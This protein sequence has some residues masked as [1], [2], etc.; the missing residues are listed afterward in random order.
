MLKR[1][2]MNKI[3]KISYVA[4]ALVCMTIQTASAQ[5]KPSAKKKTDEPTTTSPSSP[6]KKSTKTDDYFDEKGGF[7]HRLW[8]GAGGAL[9]FN[10]SGDYSLFT[11][12]LS[13]MIGYKIIGG[14]SAGPRL[15]FTYTNYKGYNTARKISSVGLI[16]YSVGA[17]V[18]YKAFQ[19][20]FAHAEYD[21][22]SIQY[23]GGSTYGIITL[24]PSGKAIKERS[25][26]SNKYL[27]LGYS[28]GGLFGYEI[29]ALYNFSITDK[30]I[31]SPVNFRAGI[32]YNF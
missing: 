23:P 18:R 13:P 26:R 4:L 9:N 19:Q 27:G 3:I 16:N 14:L 1:Q 15:G 25:G 21:Y 5:I 12:G 10:S 29:M 17:F 22:E 28:S 20:F 30:T 31:E 11:I 2:T 8:Y 6:S 32:T 24:D 7:K